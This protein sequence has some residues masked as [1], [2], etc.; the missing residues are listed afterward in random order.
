MALSKFVKIS[1]VS[2]LS[3]AR[4]CAGM[5]VDILGF[6]ISDPTNEFY[7][8]PD[9]FKELTGW[10]AGID[11]AGEIK[12]S[13]PDNLGDLLSTYDVNHL[14]FTHKSDAPLFQGTDKKLIYH[15]QVAKA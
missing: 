9:T 10:I 7:V 15:C 11:Y 12:N 8:G 13:S 2:N 14:E 3:D 4:Y 1:N 5:M 6:E